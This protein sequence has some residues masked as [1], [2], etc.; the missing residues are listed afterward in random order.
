MLRPSERKILS[1]ALELK[2]KSVGDVMTPLSKTYMLDINQ[3]LDENLKRKIYELGYSRIPIY[4]DSR[5]NIVGILMARDLIL[6]NI[7]NSLFT[8]RQLSTILVRD[9][10]AVDHKTKLEVLLTFLKRSHSHFAIVTEV[11]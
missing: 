1:A 7:D 3:Q 2:T 4:E 5:E 11:V 9:V 10:I 6:T 8:I